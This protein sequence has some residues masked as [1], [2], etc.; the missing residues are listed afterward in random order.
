M[1][2]LV[3]CLLTR[4]NRSTNSLSEVGVLVHNV[5]EVGDLPFERL[6]VVGR[7]NLNQV[8]PSQVSFKTH[9]VL[10]CVLV[11]ATEEHLRVVLVLDVHLHGGL[12]NSSDGH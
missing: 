9:N 4:L 7:G 1:F 5:V 3:E 8:R 12:N 10:H 11:S 2:L 6:L